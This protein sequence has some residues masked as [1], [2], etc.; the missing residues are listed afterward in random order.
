M[1][2]FAQNYPRPVIIDKKRKIDMST[3]VQEA[4]IHAYTAPNLN[5]DIQLMKDAYEGCVDAS[6]HTEQDCKMRLTDL[7][8]E[9]S[10]EIHDVRWSGPFVKNTLS[11]VNSPEYICFVS[12]IYEQKFRL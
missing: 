7:Y 10:K 8:E 3:I 1:E 12:E 2:Y 9:L 4:A 11:T 6:R 5:K